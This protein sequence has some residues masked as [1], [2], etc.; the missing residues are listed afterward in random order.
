[1][2]LLVPIVVCCFCILT[3]T[4]AA[5]EYKVTLFACQSSEK[6]SVRADCN[7]D[8]KSLSL[9]LN[10]TKALEKI[11]VIRFELTTLK[12]FLYIFW[13]FQLDFYKVADGKMRN[14]FKSDP[15]NWC[16]LMTKKLKGY[17][18]LKVTL[19]AFKVMA[20]EF[21]H[22]CPYVG[23]HVKEKVSLPRKFLSIYPTGSF[24]LNVVINNG[25]D[26]AVKIYHAFEIL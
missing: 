19:E 6:S 5:S 24:K 12:K 4:R 8:D 10:F 25:T 26:E 1:M 18:F 9:S 16:S 21:F 20:P 11:L 3:L 14:I 17:F 13:Q 2:S 15:L 22:Q 7:F 23:V